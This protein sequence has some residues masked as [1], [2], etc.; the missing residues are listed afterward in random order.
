VAHARPLA[1]EL[2]AY[3]LPGRSNPDPRVAVHQACAAEEVGLGSVYL[4][5]RFATKD[6]GVLGGAIAQATS[7]VTITAAATHVQTRHPLALASLGLALQ[8]LSDER[9][10]LGFGRAVPA[11]WKAQG[12]PAASDRLL[13]D[14]MDVLRR[15]WAGE[16]VSYDGP[17]GTFPSLK[18]SDRPDVV[19]PPVLLTAIGPQAL[20]LAGTHFDGALL[21]AFLTP[22]GHRRSVDAL[23]AAAEA[24]GRR[25][26]QV[27]AYGM[28]VVA[29]DLPRDEVDSRVRARLVTYLDAPK[30]GESLVAANGWDRRV[31]DALKAH[32]LVRALDGRTADGGLTVEQLVEVSAVVPDEWFEQGA[33]VGT[34]EHCAA[35]LRSVLASGADEVIVHGSTPDLLG[36]TVDAFA[37]SAVAAA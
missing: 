1:P 13:T 3:V 24:A 32:P 4:S 28:V 7:R 33:A 14:G 19:P 22:E 23:H 15:L 10:V 21:H 36:P 30:L 27:R 2:G 17:L 29:A 35:V 26:E 8:A 31:L 5:E 18:L 6:L 37:R 34:T 25:P 11:V 16:E 20:R 12:L 9:F